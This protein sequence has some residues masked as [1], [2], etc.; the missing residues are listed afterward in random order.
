MSITKVTLRVSNKSNSSVRPY[1]ETSPQ[2]TVPNVTQTPAQALKTFQTPKTASI[3]TSTTTRA[4]LWCWTSIS[5]GLT[6]TET[7][8][9][10]VSSNWTVLRKASRSVTTL[11][12]SS[13]LPTISKRIFNNCKMKRIQFQ[14]EFLSFKSKLVTPITRV[15][16]STKSRI[17]VTIWNSLWG[18]KS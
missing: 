13:P 10:R 12:I 3:L 11:E 6:L 4:L 18:N 17:T 15:H 14:V 1:K 9:I 7:K 8:I 2:T 5:L 16:S